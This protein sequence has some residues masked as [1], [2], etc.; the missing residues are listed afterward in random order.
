MSDN[1][2]FQKLLGNLVTGFR[3]QPPGELFRKPLGF[4]VRVVDGHFDHCSLQTLEF[5]IW[6]GLDHQ[7]HPALE[8]AWCETWNVGFFVRTI[9]N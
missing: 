5:L 6:V 1:A 3:K 4:V 7:G 9:L 2:V 8:T